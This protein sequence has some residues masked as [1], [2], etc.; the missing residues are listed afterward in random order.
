MRAVV[1][2]VSSARVESET[3]TPAS[4]G[5]GL[6]VLLG[7][8]AGDTAARADRLAA[9][10]CAL[11][12]FG[13]AEGRLNRSLAD[14]AGEA[15]VV[16]NF[17]VAADTSRGNRPSFAA[18]APREPARELCERV[19]EALGACGGAFGEHMRLTVENDGPVTVVIDG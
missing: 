7:V 4:I 6:V 13:D 19:R 1:Q 9:R 8:H 14:V 10:I 5:P 17:T 3:G 11:R 16:S 18:A 15:L 12:V 2:R